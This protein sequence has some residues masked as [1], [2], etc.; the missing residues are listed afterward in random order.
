MEELG[1]DGVTTVSLAKRM[2]EVFVPGRAEPIRIPRSSEALYLL[3]RIRDEAHRF[4]LTYHR[5]RRTKKM[6]QSALDGIP[7]LGEVRR[8]K[9]LKHFGSLKR[10]REATLEDLKSVPGIPGPVAEAVFETLG[11][12]TAESRAS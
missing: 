11:G 10:V 8:K 7:G 6:T 9:L 12:K 4:A 5:L 3:Q 1:V 2:E